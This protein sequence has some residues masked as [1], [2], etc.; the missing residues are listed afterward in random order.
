MATRDGLLELR[1]LTKGWGGRV[2]LRQLDLAV[3]PG[4]LVRVKGPNGAGKTTLL[5]IAA[6]LMSA[7]A[8]TVSLAGLDPEH[9]RRGYISRVGFVSAGDRGLWARLSAR[10]HLELCADLALLPATRRRAVVD[11]AIETFALESF[12]DRRVERTS[13]GQRQ[14]L[15]IALAFLHEP[16]IVLLDEPA[17]SLDD[18]GVETLARA[19]EALRARSGAALWCAPA[20]VDADIPFDERHVLAEGRVRP[21]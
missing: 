8:G 9:Q 4:R 15:R 6:G 16:D 12:A 10:R 1:G 7:D 19:L 17:S 2:V 20:T 14:R 21:E 11:R 5:R 13:M 18:D 3:A